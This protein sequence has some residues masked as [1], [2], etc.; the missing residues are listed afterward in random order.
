MTILFFVIVIVLFVFIIIEVG[1]L[2][3][4]LHDHFID[5]RC[6]KIVLLPSKTVSNIFDRQQ[7][8]IDPLFTFSESADYLTTICIW[9]NGEKPLRRAYQIPIRMAYPEL[10]HMPGVVG[11]LSHNLGMGL[12]SLTID[13]IHV[14]DDEDDFDAVTTLTW[15]K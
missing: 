5:R 1:L 12:L 14:I 13:G 3:D 7:L 15:R 6:T 4:L 10:P 11:Q 2:K 8:L 9:I